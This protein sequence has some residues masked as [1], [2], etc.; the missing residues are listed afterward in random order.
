VIRGCNFYLKLRNLGFQA[1]AY[2]FNLSCYLFEWDGVFGCS[3]SFI[4]S[5]EILEYNAR[6]PYKLCLPSPASHKV[7]LPT[8]PTNVVSS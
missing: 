4:T 2:L 5:A 3:I 8:P 1:I 6:Y 7:S